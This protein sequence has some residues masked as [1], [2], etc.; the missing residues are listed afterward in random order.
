M[1]KLLRYFQPGQF[2]FITTITSNR[3]RILTNHPHMLLRALRT[4]RRK[5]RFR[6]IAWVI[7]PDHIHAIIHCP[8][9]DV[10]EILHRFKLSFSQQWRQ[11]T[12]MGG[13][14]WQRRYWD[15]IIRSQDDFNRHVE[16]I[17]C[18]PVKHG[19]A[20][21]PQE[22]FQFSRS[23]RWWNSA[24]KVMRTTGTDSDDTIL[25]GE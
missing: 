21:K 22:W 19:L 1:S 20:G 23:H 11:R 3:Q 4:A 6:L 18:N 15:H 24:A 14:V 5:S 10:A 2:C 13:P 25:C 8:G 17:R 12:C 7:L 9:G 16:Y